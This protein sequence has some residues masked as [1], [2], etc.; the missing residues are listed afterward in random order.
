M[1]YL[2]TFD[3][4]FLAQSVGKNA[5]LIIINSFLYYKKVC[6]PL[7]NET[8]FHDQFSCMLF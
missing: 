5:S 2:A 1:Q 3:L 7:P 8:N 4:C 6:M